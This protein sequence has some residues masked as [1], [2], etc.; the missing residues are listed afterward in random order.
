[1]SGVGDVPTGR[2][3]RLHGACWRSG[4][5]PTQMVAFGWKHNFSSSLPLCA[6]RGALRRRGGERSCH[7]IAKLCA[8]RPHT[9]QMHGS[10][11]EGAK[12][13]RLDEVLDLDAARGPLVRVHAGSPVAR[14]N[15][16]GGEQDVDE[17]T[18]GRLV[19]WTVNAGS[20]RLRMGY[21]TAGSSSPSESAAPVRPLL[22]R[23]DPHRLR[24][25][26]IPGEEEAA[27][28]HPDG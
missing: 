6:K 23:R 12:E 19:Q 7:A 2:A 20:S 21:A 13:P 14:R 16:P 26:L 15:R 28:L 22:T 17:C 1:M 4:D 9:A 8:S 3:K 5:G 24:R 27:Q 10:I 11:S 25:G 18:D